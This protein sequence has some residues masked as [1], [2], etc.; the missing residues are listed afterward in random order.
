M[1]KRSVAKKRR[2]R[3]V[4]KWV[5]TTQAPLCAFGEVLRVRNVF[6]PLHDIVYVPQK[7]VEYRP[8]DKCVFLM[9]GMLSGAET[10]S[11]IQTK[12]RPDSGLNQKNLHWRHLATKSVRMPR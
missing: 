8:T 1:A 5:P 11:D 4:K 9:L 2:K 10:V 7:T 12:V 3:N 6:Q